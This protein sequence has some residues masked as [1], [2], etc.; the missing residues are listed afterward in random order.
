[1]TVVP[2]WETRRVITVIIHWQACIL[3]SKGEWHPT[4][5]EYH[6]M[7]TFYLHIVRHCYEAQYSNQSMTK[8]RI[9][10]QN[11]K[12]L[13]IEGMFENGLCN[14]PH[15]SFSKVWGLGFF[16]CFV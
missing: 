6:G 11:Q 7:T 16:N 14:G 3:S 5:F 4:K 10:F 12:N 13:K 15:Y 1:M 2:S 9:P 8:K